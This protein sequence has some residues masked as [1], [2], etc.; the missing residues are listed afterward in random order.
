MKSSLPL[1]VI[2]MLCAAIGGAPVQA[3]WKDDI[4]YT[5]LR[6]RI[7]AAL[8][9]GAG[10]VVGMAEVRYEAT[11]NQTK[12]LPNVTDTQFSGKTITD[13]TGEN[14][15]DE[16][17]SHAT[18]VARLFFGNTSSISGGVTDVRAYSA[19][20]WVFNATGAD[21]GMDPAAPDY[22][23]VNHS[24]VVRQAGMT[25]AEAA[26]YLYQVDALVQRHD[27][28]VIGGT[29]N[30]GLLPKMLAPSYNSLTVGL[31]A[32]THAAGTT[33][34][35]YG[36]GRF[37]PD[38]VAPA[39]TTSGATPMVSSA[40]TLLYQKALGTDAV[41]SE[42]MRALLM[43]GATKQEFADWDRTTIRPLDEVYGA[44]ELNVDNSYRILEGGQFSGSSGNPSSLIGD[45]GWDY[46][47][48]FDS[49]GALYYDF[50]V[51]DGFRADELSVILSWNA[52]VLDD[53]PSNL[54]DP[55][56]IDLA[57][58]DLRIY[59]SSESF[60]GTVIDE[61]LSTI[62]NVEHLYLENL[63]AGRYT[64]AVTGDQ[65]QDFAIAWRSSFSAVPEPAATGVLT[66]MALGL[67]LVHRRRRRSAVNGNPETC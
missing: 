16:Y 29:D 3:D 17:S 14:A 31:S 62:D 26:G 42:S 28:I 19:D 61:S 56:G 55:I 1:A 67:G 4:G 23:I 7:G 40:A 8:E 45:H 25:D 32:G 52:D 24:W 39:G 37:K 57:N 36:P 13:V 66:M 60:L 63:T 12:Y 10:V 6:A 9:D 41:R 35:F 64:L 50:E 48:S 34:D 11:E 20:D 44:G 33:P 5:E 18:N 22:Q 54:F 49:S 30:S 21:A 47:A 38:I 15:Q 59:D 46:Q 58:F 51:A 53:D 43:A 2:A 27:T 65:D